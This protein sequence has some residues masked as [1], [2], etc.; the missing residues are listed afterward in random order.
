MYF[1]H[2][3]KSLVSVAA[4]T[5]SNS[6]QS[7]ATIIWYL[8]LCH[9]CLSYGA[10]W[11]TQAEECT[12]NAGTVNTCRVRSSNQTS[13]QPEQPVETCLADAL[14][15]IACYPQA[16]SACLRHYAS[17]APAIRCQCTWSTSHELATWV[18]PG[19]AV[20]T[21]KRTHNQSRTSLIFSEIEHLP[22]H[23]CRY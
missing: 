18:A 20:H 23:Q 8:A 12:G 13:N 16:E 3:S 15:M 1:L 9:V 6:T 4:R 10:L 7:L 5:G 11:L 2:F 22:E 21:T 14:A 17:M 19:E